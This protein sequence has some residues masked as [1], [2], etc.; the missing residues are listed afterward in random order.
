MRLALTAVLL[1]LLGAP[2][3][4]AARHAPCRES[5]GKPRCTFWDAKVTFVAD[6]DT[7]R[8]DIKGVRGN[9][10]IRFTG[11]NAMELT[12]YSKYPRR[13]R[14][15]C[16][17]IEATTL[18][19]DAIRRSHRRIRVA[20]QKASSHSNKRLRRSVWVK[21]G[22]R[23]RDL[24]RM[25]IKRGLALWLPNGVEDAH[26]REYLQL[27]ERAAAAQKRLYDPDA[28]GAGPEQD[29]PVSLTV[30]WD[31]DGDDEANLDGEWIDVHNGGSHDLYLGGW[32][33]RD[34]W[35]RYGRDHVPG[36]R[37]PD[38]TVV[39]AGGNLRLRAGCGG[40][41]LHWCQK[42]A[43]FENV[44]GGFGTMG[45]GGYLFD[46]DGDLRASF[47]YP[48]VV[49]C[50]DPLRGNVRLDVHPSRPESITV[51]NVSSSPVDLGGHVVKYH[52]HGDPARFVFGHVFD[53]GTTLAPGG[54]LRLSPDSPLADGRGVV[55][56]R[57]LDDQVTDCVSWGGADC[58]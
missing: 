57:T 12:R 51:E 7:I 48:C 14:G 28:C 24:A 45:D 1:T 43:V 46:P 55:S 13:R 25:E 26:N 54:T 49:G 56:L 29:I 32:W 50:N 42:A 6:G 39:P 30:N 4:Q 38:G 52:L 19:D 27:A 34:S 31:A 20:A 18:V 16:H 15:A 53:P 2:A 58:R 47:I 17:G 21:A 22:G 11:I 5:G 8:A 41:G 10:T 23:W 35:L 3:A 9:K 44:T 40:T 33:L 37:I 36:Y